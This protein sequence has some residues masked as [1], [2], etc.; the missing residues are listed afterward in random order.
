MVECLRSMLEALN[1]IS[2]T[3]K[4]GSEWTHRRGSRKVKCRQ[5]LGFRTK[6]QIETWESSAPGRWQLAG[7]RRVGWCWGYEAGYTVLLAHSH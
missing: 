6:S 7:I 1:S 3:S 5:F 2:R 4:E